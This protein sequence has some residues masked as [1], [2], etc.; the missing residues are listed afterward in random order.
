MG[1]LEMLD[2]ARRETQIEIFV[3]WLSD[4]GQS[5]RLDEERLLKSAAT[6]RIYGHIVA[7]NSE[8]LASLPDTEPELVKLAL[9]GLCHAT[10]NAD[11]RYIRDFQKMRPAGWYVTPEFEIALGDM[12]TGMTEGNIQLLPDQYAMT[13]IE[14]R[15]LAESAGWLL[16]QLGHTATRLLSDANYSL[17]FT[18]KT[19]ASAAELWETS[20]V[21]AVES[22]TQE[23]M[24]HLTRTNLAIGQIVQMIAKRTHGE[25]T[26]I[27]TG[28]GT[29]ATLAAIV[30]GLEEAAKDDLGPINISGIESNPDFYET[31]QN[32]AGKASAKVGEALIPSG[33]FRFGDDIEDVT[34]VDGLTIAKGDVV[35]VLNNVERFPSGNN[36]TALVTANYVWHRLTDAVK[37]QI[38]QTVDEQT[39]NK[40]FLVA[41]LMENTSKVNRQYF[42]FGNNGPLNCGNINLAQIFMDHGFAVSMLSSA[43]ANSLQVHPKLAEA[44]EKEEANDG[45][46]WIAYKGPEAGRLLRLGHGL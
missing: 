10:T 6:S 32:F 20:I 43:S 45:R 1:T 4:R 33:V 35:D 36:D 37:T 29:G 34:S 9:L 26:I 16:S 27:D 14:G 31:L 46:L 25:L 15:T 12:Q 44:I 30:A 23:Q 42:N 2:P 40:I 8:H 5:P 11:L 38:I 13:Q 41:D 21:D 24:P 7:S 39:E 17:Y 3:D 18:N 22:D 28:S 19:M